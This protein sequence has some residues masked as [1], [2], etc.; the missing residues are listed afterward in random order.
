MIPSQCHNKHTKPL[1]KA[2]VHSIT[3]LTYWVPFAIL[4]DSNRCQAS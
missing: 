1:P 4:T 2:H 3:L